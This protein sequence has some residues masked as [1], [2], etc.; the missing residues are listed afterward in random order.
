MCGKV[1]W[2]QPHLMLCNDIVQFLSCNE[3][4]CMRSCHTGPCGSCM[5]A[6]SIRCACDQTTKSGLCGT[7]FVCEKRC[8]KERNCGRHACKRRCCAGTNCP[9]CP[10]TCARQLSCKNHTCPFPCHAGPCYPVRDAA[11]LSSALLYLDCS[12][13]SRWIWCAHAVQLAS[14]CRA[15]PSATLSLLAAHST[16]RYHHTVVIRPST[17]TSA[18]TDRARSAPSLVDSQWMA[19]VMPVVQPVTMHA[20]QLP[21]PQKPAN[22]MCRQ[23]S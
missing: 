7:S 4:K 6:S 13:R 3:H 22:A 1:C 8:T 21:P 16:V 19:A 20:H 17:P 14:P 18:T 15:G 12:A 11:C 2:E 10:E 23:L 9:P 5:I